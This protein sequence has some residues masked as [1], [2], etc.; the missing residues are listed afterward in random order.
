MTDAGWVRVAVEAAACAEPELAGLEGGAVPGGAAV[1]RVTHAGE[2]AAHLAG[3]R[4]LVGT[5]QACGECDLCRRARPHACP[6]RVELGDSAPGA[7]G[8][9]VVARARWVLPL[10]GGLDL[11]G[12]LA[13]LIAREAVDAYALLARAGVG[14]GDRVA[15]LGRGPVAQLLRA[16]ARVRGIREV[17][18]SGE[19]GEPGA[20][21]VASS[22]PADLTFALDVAAAPGAVRVVLARGDLAAGVTPGRVAALLAGGGALI[23]M[24]A[25]HPDFFAEVA[26]LV[27]K[28][29]LDLAPAAEVIE[30]GQPLADRSALAG[31]IRDA[32]AGGRALVVAMSG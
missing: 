17:I 12:P 23:G 13:A 25:G 14:A 24:P 30:T 21:L 26:A 29:E 5:I 16:L 6:A 31:R 2:G 9:E 27:A 3:R 10:E 32:L 28:G 22:E 15:I 4:V 8:G 18:P 7:L 19:E 1:G 11:P 20:V